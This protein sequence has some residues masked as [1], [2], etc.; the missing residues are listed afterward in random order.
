MTIFQAIILGLVQGLTEFLPVSSSGH[1][2]LIQKFF[3]LENTLSFDIIVHL[4]TLL[5]VIYFFR[6][7]L[8]S[9]IN[10][11][12]IAIKKGKISQIPTII[13]VI[14]ISTIPAVIF[15]FLI[16]DYLDYFSSFLFIAIGFFITS[17]LIF[18]SSNL[19]NQKSLNREISI[20]QGFII[21]IFQ[22]LAI[23]PSISRSGA[24]F[25]AGLLQK[26]EP[27]TAFNF[28]FLLSIPAILGAVVLDLPTL[29]SI[30]NQQ[31][32]AFLLGF[33]AAFITGFLALKLFKN[34]VVKNKLIYFGFY[35]LILGCICLTIYLIN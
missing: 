33:L 6:K 20:K 17:F 16:K 3:R 10:Q 8:I 29:A 32:P 15:G 26:I 25:T 21:G 1:L 22:A 9:L 4:A 19:K 5:A 31:I 35:T 7:T 24:T 28:S 13:T 12:F 14:I 18:I 23:F 11:T 30:E 34:L 27:Q 2:A